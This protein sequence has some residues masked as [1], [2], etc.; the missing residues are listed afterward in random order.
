MYPCPEHFIVRPGATGRAEIIVPLIAVDH[1]PDWI[2][3]AGV[4]RQLDAEQAMG[5]INLG[6][7]EGE[8]LST[9]EVRLRADRIR[10]IMS[11]SA[12]KDGEEEPLAPSDSISEKGKETEQAKEGVAPASEPHEP[13]DKNK[14]DDKRDT[15]LR[16][17]P[18][19]IDLLKEAAEKAKNAENTPLNH[20][21]RAWGDE[22][23]VA[24]LDTVSAASE[25]QSKPPQ[26][27]H[28]GEADS[29]T[30]PPP[31]EPMLSAS[32]HN[33][34]ADAADD[35]PDRRDKPIRPHLTEETFDKRLRRGVVPGIK[36][37]FFG[38]NPGTTYCRHWCHHGTCKWDWECRYQHRMPTNLEGL[39]EVGLK[40]FPTW[41]LLMVAG[42]GFPG[43]EGNNG[44]GLHGG[45]NSGEIPMRSLTHPMAMVNTNSLLAHLGG[46]ASQSTDGLLHAS[47]HRQLNPLPNHPSPMDL[48][49]MQGRM[50]ALLA[51]STAMS[52][53]QK[54]R[55]I[56]EMREV[57]LRSNSLQHNNP[58]SLLGLGAGY[59]HRYG[60][61]NLHTNASMAANAAGLSAASQRQALR[62]A[63]RRA[64]AQVGDNSRVGD[65]KGKD[66]GLYD[67]MEGRLSS[68]GSDGKGDEGGGKDTAVREGKLVDLE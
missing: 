42:G 67:E 4:P 40:D 12:Q 30:K 49:L 13:A 24:S 18:K 35:K 51:G 50:S 11:G 34:S 58:A 27:Q 33:T 68:M 57:F 56:K 28:E 16:D 48:R 55:Q 36:D 60:R 7:V 53:R 61:A 45:M 26:E 23:E 54:T 43:M 47:A 15:A 37:K 19:D 59:D 62:E 52:K 29:T 39:R 41:Y 10:A 8:G 63:E 38:T 6:L 66:A 64:I 25:N 46:R 20:T 14:A 1:L 32:R 3:L 44:L 31:P 9:Y 22:S 21:V 17:A 65:E 5:L 2:Q